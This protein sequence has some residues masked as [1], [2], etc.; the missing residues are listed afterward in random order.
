MKDSIHDNGVV[1]AGGAGFPAAVKLRA[2]AEVVIVNGA[3]C[4]PL[5]HK[6]KE[7]MLHH[8]AEMLR[9]LRAAMARAGALQAVVGIKE[10]DQAVIQA[11][12]PQLPAGVR[13]FP[14]S[15]TYPAGD[16]FLL[17]YDVTGR[18][19]PP[20]GLPLN[21]GAV[22]LNVETLVNIGRNRPVTHKY[23]TVAG[24]VKEPVTLR[25]PVGIS[26]G[27][28]IQAAGGATVP[29]Y[30][31]LMG[32]AM[33]GRLASG[34]EEPILK[35]TGGAIV[36]P[37]EH[38]L[39]T[40][41]RLPWSAIYRIGKSACDQCVFCTELCPRF[42]LGHPIE[43]HLAMRALMFAP[44][45]DRMIAGTLYCC[46]CNLCSLFSCPET[47]DP[48]NVCAHDKV[49][50][51]EKNL[52]WQG[53]PNEVRP[54]SMYPARRVPIRRLMQR[55]GLQSFRNVG[56][57]ED[58]PLKPK[59]VVLPLEQHAGAPAAPVV[60]AGERVKEGQL[61]AAPPEGKLGANIHA[62]ISGRVSKVDG[63]ITI[64]AT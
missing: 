44:E 54:H 46:E 49:A 32:G 21:V 22:V 60:R 40:R 43:P 13:V 5:L 42:L 20:G 25:V 36:L 33:M 2:K 63:A 26:L 39:I 41:Y 1:G 59:R 4:E 11:I 57:L 17:V 61:I 8:G 30:D 47:L 19:I 51:R 28:V 35:T 48:K 53:D 3:E 12:T 45:K 24:A 6:D 29:L 9:G 10:K 18:V 58:R 52:K 55:L 14:L 56:P 16:E 27:E 15:D 50:A 38:G 62:S 31:V 34:P 64:E 23:L 7:L 37:R